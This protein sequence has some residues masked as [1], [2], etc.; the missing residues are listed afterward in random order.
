MPLASVTMS[1]SSS[2]SAGREPLPGAAE[3]GDHLVGDEQDVVALNEHLLQRS[4]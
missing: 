1:G 3:A 2:Y 4:K